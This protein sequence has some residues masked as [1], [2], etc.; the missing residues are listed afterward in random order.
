MGHKYITARQSI[1]D[2][3]ETVIKFGLKLKMS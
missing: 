3:A 1:K 2:T